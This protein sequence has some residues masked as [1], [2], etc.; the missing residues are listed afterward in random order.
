MNEHKL[1]EMLK[2][3]MKEFKINV[4]LKPL[5]ANNG[6]LYVD[7]CAIRANMPLEMINNVLA[8][9]VAHLYLHYDQ[10]DTINSPKHEEYEQEADRAAQL[11]I[12]ALCIGRRWENGL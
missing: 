5:Q 12:D 11:L 1:F 4:K 9:E 10:G 6:L 8:H 7:R 2:F 3:I